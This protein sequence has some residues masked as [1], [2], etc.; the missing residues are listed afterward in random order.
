MVFGVSFTPTKKN[1]RRHVTASG[2]I[3]A[4]SPKFRRTVGRRHGMRSIQLNF[5]RG[6]VLEQSIAEITRIPRSD[7]TSIS[8]IGFGMLTV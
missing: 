8:M 6:C 5:V 3:S 7:S 1:I 4:Q 2:T